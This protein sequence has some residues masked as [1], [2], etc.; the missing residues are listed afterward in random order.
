MGSKPDFAGQAK[1]GNVYNA[2][3]GDY[4]GDVGY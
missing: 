3:V 2:R 4:Q 1:L